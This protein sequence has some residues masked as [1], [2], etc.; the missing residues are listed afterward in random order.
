[1][2]G[3]S[4]FGVSRIRNG[5]RYPSLRVMAAIADQCDWSLHEQTKIKLK[6]EAGLQEYAAQFRRRVLGEH[7]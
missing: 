2:L 5:N 4:S 3:L 1:M 7:D 6:G